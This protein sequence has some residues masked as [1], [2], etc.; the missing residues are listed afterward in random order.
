MVSLQIPF[1]QLSKK[2]KVILESEGNSKKRKWDHVLETEDTLHYK[3]R[4]TSPAAATTN[5]SFFDVNLHLETPLPSEW[6]RC[7]DIQ[8]GEIHFYNTR[9]QKRT[10]DP[11]NIKTQEPQSPKNSDMSLDLE[12][13]L[14]CGSRNQVSSP[15]S[16]ETPTPKMK[17]CKSSSPRASTNNLL[18]CLLSTKAED[19]SSV[20]DDDILKDD[21]D[22]E[23]VEMVATACMR[24]HMLVM[25]QKLSPTCPNCKF[26]H[27]PYQKTPELF[28]LKH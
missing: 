5:K 26:I 13:N 25:L 11:R 7:L 28:N 10:R 12:L 2:R 19:K 3:H 14:P 9:T 20:D 16:S 6:Q 8:S 22:D 15:K 21:D 24:C 4:M 17:K 1:L 27:P 23:V 18:K